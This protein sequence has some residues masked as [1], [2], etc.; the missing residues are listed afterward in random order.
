VG[1]HVRSAFR[2]AC[3]AAYSLALAAAS[4]CTTDDE[5]GQ[6]CTDPR[7]CGPAATIKI[8]LPLSFDE[9]QAS[10]IT[11]CRNDECLTGSFASLNAPPSANAGVGI[12]IA[13]TA[14]GGVA[15]GASALV[16]ASPD[17][18][19][20]LQV[21][22]PLGLLGDPVDGDRYAMTVQ[23]GTGVDVVIFEQTATSYEVTYPFGKDCPT[24]C[25]HVEW[26]K[27]TS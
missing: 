19:F 24:T 26:D 13:S 18:T 23:D 3:G 12:V 2:F 20:W 22:W 16:M 8:D 6:A 27:H 1:S 14:D 7:A 4:G 17:G 5:L 10:K 15:P 11:L 9:I 25:R 21:F